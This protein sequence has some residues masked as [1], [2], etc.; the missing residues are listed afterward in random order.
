MLRF[1]YPEVPDVVY[2]EQFNSALYVDDPVERD[3]RREQ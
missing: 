3:L 1:P 2:L